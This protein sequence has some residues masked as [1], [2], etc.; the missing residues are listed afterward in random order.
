MEF[1]KIFRAIGVKKCGSGPHFSWDRPQKG[2]RSMTAL[3]SLGEHTFG[4][5]QVWITI[6]LY[7][8]VAVN[9]GKL[10]PL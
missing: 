9:L 6:W 1:L 2:F 3:K 8:L 5:G 10:T 4:F 7:H